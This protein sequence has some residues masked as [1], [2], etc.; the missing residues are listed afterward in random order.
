[1]ARSLVLPDN[2]SPHRQGDYGHPLGKGETR[3]GK[4]IDKSTRVCGI[5][6]TKLFILSVD[7][8]LVNYVLGIFV[9]ISCSYIK[10]V[11]KA[12]RLIINWL[13]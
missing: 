4:A 8:V 7:T 9:S 10:C 1:M 6:R 2:W 12:R 3:G 13:F 5:E 11:F